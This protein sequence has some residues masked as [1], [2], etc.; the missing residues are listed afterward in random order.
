ML[1]TA[2]GMFA[3]SF[4]ATWTGATPTEPRTKSGSPLRLRNSPH[5]RHRTGRAGVDGRA[6]SSRRE[7]PA[8]PAAQRQ[9]GRRFS[10]TSFQ[11]LGVDPATFADVAYFRDD[12]ANHSL[13]ELHARSLA[14]ESRRPATDYGCRPTRA[15]SASGSTRSTSTGALASKRCCATPRAATSASRSGPT[16]VRAAGR[17]ELPGRRPD[18]G[19]RGG[20]WPTCSSAATPAAGPFEYR[21]LRSASS[22]ACRPCSGTVLLDDLQSSARRLRSPATLAP[23]ACSS[24]ARRTPRPLRQLPPWS[25]TSRRQTVWEPM[26]GI[27]AGELNDAVRLVP[28]RATGSARSSWLAPRAGQR[29]DPRSAPKRRRRGAA[30]AG[31]RGLLEDDEPQGRAT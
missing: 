23:T 27:A 17:L 16:A 8:R 11:L 24:S 13:R 15:G 4:G 9:P 26:Q 20:S 1:A 18:A 28:P 21:S 19:R 31:Q 3:A 22:P 7:T 25:R 30:G 2:V 6:P 29:T 5:R 12:F 14:L 10:P